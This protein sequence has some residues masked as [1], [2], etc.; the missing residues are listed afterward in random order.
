MSSDQ[1]A[2]YKAELRAQLNAKRN[3]RLTELT[4]EARVEQTKSVADALLNDEYFKAT[5]LVESMTIASYL[6]LPSEP[7]TTALHVELLARGVHVLVPECVTDESGT[8]ALAWIELEAAEV[9]AEL[10]SDERGIPIPTGKRIGIGAGG[11]GETGCKL[12]ILPAL[13]VSTQG[14]R[15]GKGAGYYD[16]LLE[17][18]TESET[19]LTTMALVFADEVLDVVPTDPHDQPVN[20]WITV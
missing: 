7:D 2:R 4:P 6:S 11:L 10:K 1:T 17:Q 8:P 20:S 15:L 19:D 5:T 16:R 3:Q 12:L 18:A 14:K 9:D 13:A